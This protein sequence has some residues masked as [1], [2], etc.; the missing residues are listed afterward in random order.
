MALM[1]LVDELRRIDLFDGLTDEQLEEWAAVTPTIRDVEDGRGDA[2]AGGR[3]ARAAAALRRHHATGSSDVAG[4][5]DPATPNPA[6]TWIGAIAA[7][8]ES[9]LPVTI[10]AGVDCRVAIIPRE[11]FIELALK[12]RSVHRKVM[13]R[14]RPGDARHATRASPAA[15]GSRRWARW[16]P[17]SRTSSTTR[18]RPRAAPRATWSTR[19]RSSTTRCG[20]S[21][22]PA[23]SASTPRSCSRSSR[24]RSSAPRTARASSA[25]DASDAEDA[26]QDILEE[27]GI[28]RGLDA[29]PSR[30]A[31]AGLDEDWVRRVSP[32]PAQGRTRR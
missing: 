1:T 25:I 12:H 22:S 5:T 28:E 10:V 9:E 13:Q 24:R 3:L 26:M 32:S 27:L 8:T 23:S 21:S 29:S 20:A 2:R 16:P 18:P 15:S 7:I 4:G 14:D 11:Q 17:G 19:C 30:S 6:P 31:S